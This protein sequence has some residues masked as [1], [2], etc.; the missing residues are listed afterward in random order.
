MGERIEV[1]MQWYRAHECLVQ[2]VSSATASVLLPSALSED[3]PYTVTSNRTK[4]L[5]DINVL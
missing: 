3:M 1:P 4:G 2:R 5:A